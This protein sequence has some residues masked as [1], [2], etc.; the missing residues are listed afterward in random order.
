[1]KKKTKIRTTETIVEPPRGWL[2]LRL[3]EVWDFRELLF[4]L[5]WR[6]IAVRYKQTALGVL[7]A[8]IQPVMTMVI[9][10]VVFGKLAKLPS[11]GIPYPIFS[12]TAVLPWQ[13]FSS[14]V[15]A[16]T[17]C[18]V[19]NQNMISKTYFPR[20]ILP[21][22]SVLSGLVDFG[23]AFLVLFGMM[24]YYQIPFTWRI[25]VLPAFILFAIVTALAAGL[26]LATLNVRFRDIKYII[27]FLMQFWQYATPIAYSSSLI[28][29]QWRALYG[30]NPM[31][32]VMDGFRWAML[33]QSINFG[34]MFLVSFIVVLVLL[35]SGLFYFQRM[36]KT[37]ADLI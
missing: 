1:M 10:S 23:I 22:S 33:G 16:A 18:V 11:D 32:G 5:I 29:E 9:F 2:N 34:P 15:G 26:W 27:P 21:I 28:P 35:I 12:Y 24:F 13:L 36:E 3:D 14:G 37:F 4:F 25:L 17:S 20:L 6:D 30:L 8:I 7:W 19:G 31:A